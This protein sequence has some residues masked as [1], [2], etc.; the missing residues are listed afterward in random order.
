MLLTSHVDLVALNGLFIV[1]NSVYD[2]P[3][4]L[5]IGHGQVD[6]A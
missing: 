4:A 6:R 5:M 3:A 1:C 2:R